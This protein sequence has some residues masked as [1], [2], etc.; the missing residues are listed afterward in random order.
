MTQKVSRYGCLATCPPDWPSCPT[1][2]SFYSVN[3]SSIDEG[4]CTKLLNAGEDTCTD[5]YEYKSYEYVAC[6]CHGEYCNG[7]LVKDAWNIG[8]LYLSTMGFRHYLVM[9]EYE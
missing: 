6:V 5:E 7:A 4:H 2:C 8:F 3:E 9:P 1:G